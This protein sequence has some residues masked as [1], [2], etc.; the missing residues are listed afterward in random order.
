MSIRIIAGTYRGCYID[1]PASA[2]PTLSR[3]RQALFDTLESIH[4]NF[5]QDA[6]V[7]DCFAGSGGLGIEAISRGAKFVYFVDK[8]KE[9]FGVIKN[10]IAKLRIS[11]MCK[12]VR[13]DISNFRNQE[14]NHADVIFVDPPY[15][16]ISIEKTVR[17]L[18]S[19]GWITEN[20][21]IITEEHTRQV[22]SLPFLKLKKEKTMGISL[23]RVFN[24]IKKDE[25]TDE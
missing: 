17:H 14:N 22:E 10:N 4:S 8:D 6:V 3:F 18:I 24:Q 13:S 2:R 15:G 25:I 23:F 16:E 19:S 11:D 21:Y 12:V 1:A 20:S 7:L 5:F 9:A